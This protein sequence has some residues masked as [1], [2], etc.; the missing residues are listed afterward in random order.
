MFGERR[1]HLSLTNSW[2]WVKSD[3]Y[4]IPYRT[5]IVRGVSDAAFSVSSA[6]SRWGAIERTNEKVEYRFPEVPS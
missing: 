2:D 6:H 3:L 1:G 5:Q 4:K